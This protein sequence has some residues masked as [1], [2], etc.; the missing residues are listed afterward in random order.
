MLLKR[1]LTGGKVVWLVVLSALAAGFWFAL[2]AARTEVGATI[3]VVAYCVLLTIAG[4]AAVW[5]LPLLL[6][7]VAPIMLGRFGPEYGVAPI[8]VGSLHPVLLVF[9]CGLAFALVAQKNGIDTR[10]VQLALRASRTHYWRFLAL[11]SIA[12]VWLS[13][14]ISSVAAAGLIFAAIAPALPRLKLTVRQ[15]QCLMLV[16]AGAANL[17]GMIS[18]IG[19]GANAIAISAT[20]S[21]TSISFLQW[22]LFATPLTILSIALLALGSGAVLRPGGDLTAAADRSAAP[23]LPIKVPMLF[24]VTVILWLSEPLHHV[25]ASTVS[26]FALVAIPLSRTLAVRDL[27]KLDWSTVLLVMGGISIGN[28]IQQSGAAEAAV[29]AL[30]LADTGAGVAL[31]ILC[32]AAAV[33]SS[34]MS[35][36][37]TAATLIPVAMLIVPHPSTA[38]LIALATSFGFPLVISTPANALA[39]RH[40]GSQLHLLIAGVVA[41]FVGSTILAL[42]GRFVLALAGIK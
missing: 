36:T 20:A 18:P 10:F 15:Q 4:V 40:G 24:G 31:F 25:E 27:R 13:A 28:L 5:T 35:N 39:L 3:L 11:I 34:V 21:D 37:G 23:R 9:T 42:T 2:P 33:L 26:L 38:I 12:T 19:A 14:W 6:L 32:A 1:K 16:L 41:I 7:V 8:L 29:T 22:L 17:G 30:A